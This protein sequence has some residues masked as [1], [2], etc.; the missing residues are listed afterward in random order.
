MVP[1][2]LWKQ[3]YMHV[4][5]EVKGISMRSKPLRHCPHLRWQFK[6]AY[7][8]SSNPKD[9]IEPQKKDGVNYKISCKRLLHK[10]IK[11]HDRDVRLSWPQTLAVSFH[12]NKTGV[13]VLGSEVQR[14]VYIFIFCLIKLW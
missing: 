8:I 7:E 9:A 4:Q 11:E 13:G 10:R 12:A 3:Q 14:T 2:L 5:S 1:E 6:Q